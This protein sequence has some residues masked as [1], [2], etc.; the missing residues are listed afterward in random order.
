[1]LRSGSRRARA[2]QMPH[3][4]NSGAK[5]GRI[6]EVI[7]SARAHARAE[8]NVSQSVSA[9]PARRQRNLGS[10]RTKALP[11]TLNAGLS[12]QVSQWRPAKGWP[13]R[14]DLSRWCV[15]PT[16]RPPNPSLERT[17]T[18]L[19]LGPRGVPV[20]SSASRPKHQP[21]GV[22]S[23]QTLCVFCQWCANFKSPHANA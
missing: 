19:A 18:G 15:L 12:G 21:G 23:A 16:G 7:S 2:A 20:L 4:R 10:A 11:A 6:A 9:S 8:A 1:M 22:R 3:Q 17:S 5:L 14:C 13:A